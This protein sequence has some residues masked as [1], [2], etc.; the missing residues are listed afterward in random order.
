MSAAIERLVHDLRFGGRVL[1]RSP[2]VSLLAVASRALGIK[3]TTA[4]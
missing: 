2:G 1:L 3:A 4:M